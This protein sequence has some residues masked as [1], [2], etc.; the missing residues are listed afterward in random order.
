MSKTR[1]Q[2]INQI[3]EE[4]KKLGA[5][6]V[7]STE[8]YEKIDDTIDPV[9]EEL[10]LRDIVGGLDLEAIPDGFFLPLSQVIARGAATAFGMTG[11][12][13]VDAITNATDAERRLLAM[14]LPRATGQKSQPDYF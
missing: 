13:L 8:D 4:L 1:E 5:G 7:M 11:Q 10:D 3:G 9:I 6:Q 2:L 12:E 14:T